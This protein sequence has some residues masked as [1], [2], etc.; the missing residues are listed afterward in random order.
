MSKK[1]IMRE[2]WFRTHMYDF[3]TYWQN[4]PNMIL[5]NRNT[6]YVLFGT[7]NIVPSNSL[8]FKRKENALWAKWHGQIIGILV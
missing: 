4:I 1:E 6:F 5:C 8:K 2:L 3:K 7:V